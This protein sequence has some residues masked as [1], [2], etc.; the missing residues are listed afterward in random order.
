MGKT[1]RSQRSSCAELGDDHQA[2]EVGGANIKKAQMMN[3]ALLA[4][5]A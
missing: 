1:W 2:E 4:K 3:W 5:L